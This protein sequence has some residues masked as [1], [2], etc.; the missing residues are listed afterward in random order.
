MN[1]L[2]CDIFGVFQNI[3][4]NCSNDIE[5]AGDECKVFCIISVMKG[6]EMCSR[7]LFDT[8]LLQ[9]FKDLIKHCMYNKNIDDH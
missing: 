9:Q 3:T 7:Y 4:N 8:E 1:Y 6:I 5:I 2:N